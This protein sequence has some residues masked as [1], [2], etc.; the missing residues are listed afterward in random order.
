MNGD[1]IGIGM[2]LLVIYVFFTIF[3]TISGFESKKQAKITA[4]GF[5]VLVIFTVIIFCGVDGT[6]LKAALYLLPLYFMYNFIQI[7]GSDPHN[8]IWRHLLNTA[9]AGISA[10]LIL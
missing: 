8:K 3:T 1:I 6:V 9:I 5:I 2:F 7:L 4:V 10:V